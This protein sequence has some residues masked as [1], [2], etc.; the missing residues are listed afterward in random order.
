MVLRKVVVRFCLVLCLLSHSISIWAAETLQHKREI[1]LLAGYI[2][3][4][5]D[6]DAEYGTAF[7]ASFGIKLDQAWWLEPSFVSGVIET[8]DRINTDYYHQTL[9]ADVVYRFRPRAEFVPF[10]LA[11]TGVSRNDVFDNRDSEIGAYGNLGLGVLSP[12]LTEFGLR[13]RAEA[14]YL[15]DTFDDGVDDVHLAAGITVPIGATRRDI[16]ER[17]EYVEK[18]V[19]VEKQVMI[20][21][22]DSDRDGVV[23]GADQCPNTLKGLKVDAVGCVK[24][25]EAQK[26]VLL[27]VS[28][29]TNSDRLT[30]N[31]RDILATTA[32]G[33]NGQPDLTVEIAGHTDSVGDADYNLRLSRQ[34][35]QAVKDYLVELGVPED[36]LSAQGYGE[37]SPIQSNDNREGRE[38]NRRVEF[39]V[40]SE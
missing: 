23:D 4:D 12:S 34:R 29:D 10:A 6:R 5:S 31:A 33:L 20:E 28:F 3:E 35:A 22:A 15:H 1:S 11:G 21:Q 32:E 14:R 16:V 25:D 24:T 36:Q 30:A 7:R 13:V 8:D 18:P 19:V 27:G 39:N 17:V 9:G 40:I 37:T 2:S 38:R 26:L